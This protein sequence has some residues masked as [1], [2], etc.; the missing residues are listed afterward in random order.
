MKPCNE[1]DAIKA[2][3]AMTFFCACFSPFFFS[4]RMA[5]WGKG[6]SGGAQKVV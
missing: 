2:P 4:L 3:L 6:D 1:L 5:N